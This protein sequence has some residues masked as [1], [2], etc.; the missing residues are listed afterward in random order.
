MTL[1]MD[2]P[3]REMYQRHRN[4]F[5]VCL[6]GLVV[7]EVCKSIVV[8]MNGTDNYT[9]HD[10]GDECAN[11]RDVPKAQELFQGKWLE[12]VEGCMG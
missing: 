9:T 11:T 2:A 7:S 10:A 5:K 4:C 12:L 8:I 6:L 3:T 1:A